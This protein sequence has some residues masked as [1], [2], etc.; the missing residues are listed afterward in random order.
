LGE[1]IGSNKQHGKKHHPAPGDFFTQNGKRHPAPKQ[2]PDLQRPF[3][4][5]LLP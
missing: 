2:P 4:Q 5:Q 3:D 1:N